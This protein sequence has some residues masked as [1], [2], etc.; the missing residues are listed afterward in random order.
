MPYNPS[1][2]WTGDPSCQPS[3]YITLID[4]LT[5]GTNSAPGDSTDSISYTLGSSASGEVYTSGAM[6]FNQP[7]LL[8]MPLPPGSVDISGNFTPSSISQTGAQALCYI[9]NDQ[10]TVFATRDVRSQ[11]I[12][13]NLQ[14]GETCLYG[15]LGKGTVILKNDSTVTLG[16]V[17]NSSTY[18]SGSAG[19]N[20]SFTVGPTGLYFT[21]P[22]GTM[23]FDAAGFRVTTAGG[24]TFSLTNSPTSGSACFFNAG[25]FA[26]N[27]SMVTL[28]TGAN[29][30]P[31]GVAY[32]IVPAAA[33]GIPILGVGVGAVTVAASA[34]TTVFVSI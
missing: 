6:H 32:G 13:G 11:A 24:G 27:S 16:S 5:V 4:V 10:Y 15:Q 21:S 20:I 33:P 7:G 29:L 31:F 22:W 30:A 12:A 26:V 25:S 1:S 28:G 8:S 23:G 18:P 34:S 2:H 9:R 3:E 14:L 19:Q 17:A